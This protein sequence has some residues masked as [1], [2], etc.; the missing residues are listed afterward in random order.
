MWAKYRIEVCWCWWEGNRQ[1]CW[2]TG[3]WRHHKGKKWVQ[4]ALYYVAASTDTSSITIQRGSQRLNSAELVLPLNLVYSLNLKCIYMKTSCLKDSPIHAWGRL[5]FHDKL[6]ICL[7][8]NLKF[9]L[10]TYL[11]GTR[12][13]YFLRMTLNLRETNHNHGLPMTTFCGTTVLTLWHLVFVLYQQLHLATLV[14]EW[15][16]QDSSGWHHPPSAQKG[17]FLLHQIQQ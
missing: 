6:Y 7:V 16:N 15:Q 11:I 9:T 1:S 17:T 5:W 8:T 2:W 12:V 3:S 14:P 4:L 10:N 13:P